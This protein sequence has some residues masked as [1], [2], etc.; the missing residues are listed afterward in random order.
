MSE[1][2][3]AVCPR[4]RD[5]F[6]FVKVEK[7]CEDSFARLVSVAPAESEAS[8]A[9]QVERWQCLGCKAVVIH[10]RYGLSIDQRFMHRDA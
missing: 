8:V 2:P 10:D 3:S 4:C 1:P 5:C 7:I 6:L 9:E